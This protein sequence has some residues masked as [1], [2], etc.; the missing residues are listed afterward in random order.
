MPST[1]SGA[2]DTPVNKIA[3]P[4]LS[5]LLMLWRASQQV[6]GK[7]R[8][9]TSDT[10]HLGA[11]PLPI[12]LPVCPRDRIPLGWGG[13]PQFPAPRPAPLALPIIVPISPVPSRRTS[14]G[15]E[16]AR[17]LRYSHYGGHHRKAGP[18]VSSG[19][20]F[21]HPPAFGP[22]TGSLWGPPTS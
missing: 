13:D 22:R 10:G 17:T 2:G 5:M 1:V 8:I 9:L 12:C 3:T 21:G 20:N 15:A 11:P 4:G 16:V 18:P 14:W 7:A 19:L 6:R